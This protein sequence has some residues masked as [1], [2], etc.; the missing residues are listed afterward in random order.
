MSPCTEVWVKLGHCSGV[1]RWQSIKQRGNNK[2]QTVLLYICYKG[3][4]AAAVCTWLQGQNAICVPDIC[5]AYM[6]CEE[7]TASEMAAVLNVALVKC[8]NSL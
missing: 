7:K 8:D 5:T 3:L 1:S 2:F 4:P 6:Q